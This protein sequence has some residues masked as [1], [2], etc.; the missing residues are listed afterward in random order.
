MVKR[1]LKRLNIPKSWNIYKKEKFTVRPKPGAHTFE[2]GMPLSLAIRDLL[3]YAKTSN[4]VKKILNNKEIIVD[5]KIRKNYR[6]MVGF[7][8]VV[9]IPKLKK[10]YRVI[11]NKKGRLFLLQIT[12]QEAKVKV[13]KIIGKKLIKGK[14]QLNLLDSRNI[15]VDKD[16]YKVGDSLL[17]ELPGQNIKEHIKLEKG[18]NVF[19]MGGKKTGTLCTVEDI[20]GRKIICKHE[21]S[22]FEVLFDYVFAVGKDKALIRLE[23]DVKR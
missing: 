21:N 2:L 10:N 19:V 18:A 13:C 3:K 8:D 23:E 4:E 9:S 12:E 5:G 6:F 22:I 14:T 16:S 1:H 7:M 11:L 15:L 17:I 20:K